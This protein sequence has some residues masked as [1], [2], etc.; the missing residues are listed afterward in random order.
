MNAPMHV[1][2]IMEVIPHRPPFLL[3]DRIEEL[4]PGVRAVGLKSVTMN[5]PYFAGHFPGKPVMP[6]VLQIEAL[7]Q[8]GAVAI[9]SLPENRGKLVYFA[10]IDDFRFKCPVTPGETLRLEVNIE[11]VRGPIGK[12]RARATSADTLVCEGGLTFAVVSDDA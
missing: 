7:A 6:G 8:V 2:Q 3:I 5:E 12:G 11:K 1:E 9:L 10:A 4:E